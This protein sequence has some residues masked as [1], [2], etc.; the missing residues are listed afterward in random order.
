[1]PLRTF[2]STDGEDIILSNI[3]N[4]SLRSEF[5]ELGIDYGRVGAGT[6][7]IHN[8]SDRQLVFRETKRKVRDKKKRQSAAKAKAKVDEE[9]EK[10]KKL[11]E[12][13]AIVEDSQG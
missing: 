11:A 8:A 1:M 13:K 10:K 6:T 2:Y 3:F 5:H 7:G 4:E 9:A 12:A